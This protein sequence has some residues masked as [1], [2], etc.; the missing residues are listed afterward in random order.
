MTPIGRSVLALAGLAA[1]GCGLWSRGHFAQEMRGLPKCTGLPA[2]TP[3]G[4]TEHVLSEGFS[5]S[6]PPCFKRQDHVPDWDPPHGG[7]RWRCDDGR[8][9]P[10]VRPTSAVDG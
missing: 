6:L 4:W 2:A 7:T 8:S 3:S 10:S 9:G 5:I 1:A